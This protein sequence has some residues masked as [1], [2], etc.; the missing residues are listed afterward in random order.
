M[1][2][3]NGTGIFIHRKYHKQTHYSAKLT[4]NEMKICCFCDR[5]ENQKQY[6]DKVKIPYEL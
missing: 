6:K 1:F 2:Y 3:F 5:F 4:E